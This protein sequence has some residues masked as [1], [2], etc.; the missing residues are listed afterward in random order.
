MAGER[1]KQRTAVL[2]ERAGLED[3]LENRLAVLQNAQVERHGSR[4]DT[5]Y[6]GHMIGP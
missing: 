6:P 1:L 5:G 3:L 4:V 2:A